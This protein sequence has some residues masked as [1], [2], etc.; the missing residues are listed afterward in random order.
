LCC[1]AAHCQNEEDCDYKVRL[2]WHRWPP[3]LSVLYR[4]NKNVK[5]P[6]KGFYG[7]CDEK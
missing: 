7:V 4:K 1:T 3:F 6:A 2:D 5:A